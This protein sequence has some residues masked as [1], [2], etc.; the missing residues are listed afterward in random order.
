MQPNTIIIS[1][2]EHAVNILT[3]VNTLCS[4]Q[5]KCHLKVHQLLFE[6]QAQVK[7]CLL[8]QKYTT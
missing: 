3:L 8:C 7:I 6:G 2:T 1:W 4:C 5:A